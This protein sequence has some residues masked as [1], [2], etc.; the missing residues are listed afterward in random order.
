MFMIL[1]CFQYRRG[2]VDTKEPSG[3]EAPG[4]V[5]LYGSFQNKQRSPWGYQL[6]RTV[7]TPISLA[8]PP[9]PLS[10]CPPL[11]LSCQLSHQTTRHMY[12]NHQQLSDG[13]SGNSSSVKELSSPAFFSPTHSDIHLNHV[14]CMCSLSLE[15]DVHRKHQHMQVQSAHLDVQLVDL[16][17][18]TPSTQSG[19]V[20][21]YT[22]TMHEAAKLEDDDF[23]NGGDTSC[24]IERSSQ[25]H[26]TVTRRKM[27]SAEGL[28][29]EGQQTRG[30]NIKKRAVTER[31]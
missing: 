26:L 25:T 12:R 17:P 11:C 27:Y 4:A 13:C 3:A 18:L 2:E 8:P 16:L 7:R 22:F 23:I 28:R 1:M 29:S 30:W 5:G 14:E 20:C 15:K 21:R 31:L 9:K 10:L 24:I 19:Y 6:A